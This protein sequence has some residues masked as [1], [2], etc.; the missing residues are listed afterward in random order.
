MA[1]KFDLNIKKNWTLENAG[2]I[3][4]ELGYVLDEDFIKDLEKFIK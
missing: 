3:A 1:E 4:H 2:K